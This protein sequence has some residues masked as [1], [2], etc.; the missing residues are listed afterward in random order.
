M[1]ASIIC[2]VIMSYFPHICDTP[3][4]LTDFYFYT[5]ELEINLFYMTAEKYTVFLH[6]YFVSS[7]QNSPNNWTKPES[8]AWKS[9]HS[10]LYARGRWQKTAPCSSSLAELSLCCSTATHHFQL[11][12]KTLTHKD[13]TSSKP[14]KFAHC[15]TGMLHFLGSSWA[16]GTHLRCHQAEHTASKDCSALG[17][18]SCL[19]IYCNVPVLNCPVTAPCNSLHFQKLN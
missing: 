3:L 15:K 17:V 18:M 7:G 14:T 9:L 1:T 2:D 19:S 5:K 11:P 10:D 16:A 6:R 13:D 8:R 12:G 4:F